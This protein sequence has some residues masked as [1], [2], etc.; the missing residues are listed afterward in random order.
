M[1]QMRRRAAAVLSQNSTLYG[2][3][4]TKPQRSLP[5][6]HP[7]PVLSPLATAGR[8]ATQRTFHCAPRK[9]LHRRS[10]LH[11][12]SFKRSVHS[13]PVAG[14]DFHFSSHSWATSRRITVRA[15]PTGQAPPCIAHEHVTSDR[16]PGIE[17]D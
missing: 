6:R 11:L 1:S 15:C 4:H 7:L 3:I 14:A 16:T 9:S 8:L 5:R 12:D 2:A 13:L 17:I 10:G